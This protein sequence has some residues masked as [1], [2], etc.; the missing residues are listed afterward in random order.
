MSWFKDPTGA[1]E[2]ERRM[3]RI[4]DLTTLG[5]LAIRGDKRAHNRIILSIPALLCPVENGNAIVDAAIYVLAKDVSD[6]GV[7][8]VLHQPFAVE[9]AILGI[10]LGPEQST[11]PWFFRAK[12][13]RVR[14]MGGGLASLGVELVSFLNNGPRY[15]YASL[16]SAAEKLTPEGGGPKPPLSRSK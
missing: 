5:E 10:W 14:P 2:I 1:A 7:G 13:T 9:H 6:E 15:E 3:R 11:E 8:L 16:L 12:V 4:C